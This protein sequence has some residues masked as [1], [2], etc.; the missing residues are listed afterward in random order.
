M[1]ASDFFSSIIVFVL[2]L[3]FLFD[4]KKNPS[5]QSDYEKSRSGEGRYFL[6]CLFKSFDSSVTRPAVA[7]VA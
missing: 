1:T 2:R 7:G 5:K 6:G 4:T 3:L